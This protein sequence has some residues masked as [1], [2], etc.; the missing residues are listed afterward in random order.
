MTCHDIEGTTVPNSSIGMVE[1]MTPFKI[2]WADGSISTFKGVGQTKSKKP[3]FTPAYGLTIHKAQGKTLKRHVIINPS[4]LFSKNHLY[5]AL[6]RATSFSNVFFTEK[7]TYD[8]FS[9]TV[10]VDDSTRKTN[11]PRYRPRTTRLERML[12]TY[13]SEEPRLTLEF[14]EAMKLQQKNMCCYCQ[15][16]MC[17]LHGEPHSITLERIDDSERHVLE[18]IKMACSSCNS[19]HRKS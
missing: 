19:S 3:R 2:R 10:L 12:N 6:T 7:M 5:V 17:D 8:V 1:S 4:R 18:N 9:K 14:L 15:V 16:S 13:V 11:H